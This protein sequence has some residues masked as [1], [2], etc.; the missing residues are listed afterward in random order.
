MKNEIK[1]DTL[2]KKRYDV[3]QKLY[4][5]LCELQYQIW[6]ILMPY[7]VR[8]KDSKIPDPQSL[9][10]AFFQKSRDFMVKYSQNSIYFSKSVDE[11]FVLIIDS[12][13]K[14]ASSLYEDS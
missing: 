11:K 13:S 5:E 1:F 8:A 14:I 4:D 10:E 12:Y 2:H 6:L 9:C 7:N 3:I